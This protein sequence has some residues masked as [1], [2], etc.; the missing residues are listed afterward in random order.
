MIKASMMAR[1]GVRLVLGWWLLG[2]AGSALA[3]AAPAERAFRPPA[4]PLIAH[5][6]Y[7]SVWSP[8]DRLTDADTVHWTGAPQP[9]GCLAR[10]DGRPFRLMGVEPKQLPALPQVRLQVWPTRTVYELQNEQVRLTMTFTTPALPSDLDLLARP[11]TYLTWDVASADGKEHVVEIYLEVAANIAVNAPEQKVTWKQEKQGDLSLLRVGTADQNVLMRKGDNLRIDWGY[12]YAAAN[13]E[14]MGDSAIVPAA[15]AR[16]AFLA[17][18][19]LPDEDDARMPRAVKDDAPVLAMTFV[20]G[21]IGS[22]SIAKHVLLAYDDLYSIEYFK[23]PLRPYW[24]RNGAEIGDVLKAAEAD[25][26]NLAKQ[27][28][29]FDEELMADLTKAGGVKYARIA[30]LAYRQCLAANKLAAD[31][32]GMPLLFPKENFSNGCI[33]TVD[34]IYPQ[35]PQ[36]LLTNAALTKAMLVPV[37]DY[38]RS[39]RWPFPYAPHDLG[40]YPKANG[41]VYGGGE[42]NERGQMPVE[43]SGNMLIVLAALAEAEGNADF[44]KLYW[45]TLTRWAEYLRDKGLDPENQLCTD[46]FAGH[47]AH[48]VN[49]SAKA[50]VA[51]ASYG[52]LCGRL[53]HKAEADQYGKLAR[54]Y[55]QRWVQMADDGD[56]T[57]LA[58]DKP[59][60]WSQKYNLVWDRLLGYGLFPASVT[61]REVAF[62]KKSLNSYGLPLDNRE[63]YTKL[64]WTI[65]TATLATKRADFNAIVAPTYEF[66]LDTTQRV[67]MTDWHWTLEPKQRGFQARSVVGGVFI[68]LL[69]D[70]QTW[71]KWFARGQKVGGTWAPLVVPAP[72]KVIVPTAREEAVA[73]RF[74]TQKPEAKWSAETFDDSKWKQG[75]AG[76]GKGNPPRS[77]IRTKWDTTDIWLR[78]QFTLDKLPANPRLYLHHDE[79]VEVYINGVLAL[80]LPGY[81]STYD[82]YAMS[83]A[84]RKALRAGKN[85]FA[86][87]CRQ[88]T[89]GQYI[90]LGLASEG[91]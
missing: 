83:E 18:K 88:T 13:A 48:N 67:P 80:S 36:L 19:A 89:G 29:V 84:A 30:A 42:V 14:Q 52:A 10:I 20:P 70:A 49:L 55:A 45:P 74:T 47:L 62:Y 12:F 24:R 81:S 38:A 76:F 41:Q 8:A 21:R 63:T 69:A 64:D 16:A 2:A 46:D 22:R 66:L 53:G 4:V 65:W 23:K 77:V 5:D 37:L 17:G 40:T 61:E 78:R 90:D 60:T 9:I 7:F 51:L 86:V 50:I 58:F 75:P 91:P 71:R 6:P 15:T 79:D 28:Q 43:E 87:H 32:A 57:R 54:D 25:Y 27:C 3:W 85:T 31:Q 73:W 39:S 72:A 26:S 68:P 11:V 1:W 56:H 82:D 44:A 35:A 34:V 59:G 33:A